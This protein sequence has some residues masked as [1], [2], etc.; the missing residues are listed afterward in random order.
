LGLAANFCVIFGFK[1]LA[2][3]FQR[4]DFGLKVLLFFLGRKFLGLELVLE[5]A[6]LLLKVSDLVLVFA[7]RFVISWGFFYRIKLF[8][9]FSDLL[10]IFLNFQLHGD[11]LFFQ[12][13]SLSGRILQRL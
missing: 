6:N 13:I 9:F 5:F 1:I 7:L 10:I 12:I 11:N 8:L 2:F 3:G 4:C